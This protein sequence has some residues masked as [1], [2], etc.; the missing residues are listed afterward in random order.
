MKFL[1]VILGTGFIL[2]AF[3][4]NAQLFI[5]LRSVPRS[6]PVEAELYLASNINAW[7]PGDLQ[8]KFKKSRDGS[9]WLTIPP[10]SGQMQFKITR[11]TWKSV[12]GDNI[13]RGISNRS[14]NYTK[15]DT[16]HLDIKSWEDLDGS[17]YHPSTANAQVKVLDTA[18][19][20]P[21]L[22]RYRK[23]TLYIPADYHQS[24]KRYPVIYMM[25]GQNIFDDITSYAGEWRV[26]ETLTKL[27]KSGKS[28]AIVVA[29]DNGGPLRISEYSPYPTDK[30]GK[31]DGHAYAQFLVET[32]KPKIDRQF[33]TLKDP[34]HTAIV[35]SSLGALIAHYAYF[36]YPNVF[37]RVGIFSPSYWYIPEFFELCKRPASPFSP[38]IYLLA[39]GQ[40]EGVPERVREMYNKLIDGGFTPSELRISIDP[41]G[42][43]SEQFWA[44]KFEEAFLWLMN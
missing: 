13:G 1:K 9:Y 25:D 17:K 23:I 18:M 27:E 29:I 12:E 33:R 7:N 44:T 38:K 15:T 40:E 20:M 24:E 21:Q 42:N 26:D 34:T 30:Y 8:K 4:A 2:L 3:F 6:T 32:L 37:G 5:H 28:S 16:I 35:G 39:G 10:V 31:D 43:H 19:W 41:N 14:I 11:G 36:H 22:Q